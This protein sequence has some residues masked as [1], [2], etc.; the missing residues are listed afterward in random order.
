VN[1]TY[2]A[3]LTL[4][5]NDVYGN[6]VQGALVTFAVP[7]TGAGATL[8]G[9]SASVFTDADGSARLPALTAN[10][11][12]GAFQVTATTAGVDTPAVFTL[13]NT[14]GAVAKLVF[15]QQPSNSGSQQPV[16]PAI[17]VQLQDNSGNA[18]N[19]SGVTVS[20]ALSPVSG[21]FRT[22]GG[23]I[24]QDTNANGAATFANLSVGKAGTYQ[25]LALSGATSAL[26]SSFSISAGAAAT[27]TATNGSPQTATI[28]TQFG[29]PLQATVR[30]AFGNLVS[31][32]LVAFTAPGSG[33]SATLSL[34]TAPTNSNGQV[35]VTAGANETSGAYAV[36][37]TVPGVN[38]PASFALTNLSGGPGSLTFI[39]Q[40]ANTPAGTLI[41]P[42]TVTL[43][44]S[45]G[46]AIASAIVIVTLTSGTGTLLGSRQQ[47][48]GPGGV[49]IFN[50]LQINTAG[51]YQLQV[52][53]GNL[54]A[55]SSPFQITSASPSAAFIVTPYS[56]DQQNAAIGTAYGT[57]LRALVTDAF[58]NPVVNQPVTFTIPVSGA[59]AAF[60]GSA[61]VNTDSNGLAT[62]PPLIANAQTGAFQASAAT[63][64][65]QAGLFNLTNLPSSANKLAFTQQP[66]NTT[67]GQALTPPA[68]AQLQDAS[69]NAAAV[70][71]V[72]ITLKL[73]GSGN[74]GALAGDTAVTD[75]NGRASFTGLS[76]T[77]VGTYQLLARTTGAVSALSQSFV[78]AAGGSGSIT[79]TGGVVQSTMTSATFGQPLQATVR[80]GYGN[81]ATGVSVTFT[82]PSS[83]AS[84]TFGGATSA[85]VKTDAAGHASTTITANSAAGRFAVSAGAVA[86]T[87]SA[88]FT[89]T[90]LAAPTTVLAFT[91]Q[92]SDTVS[93]QPIPSVAVQI[94]DSAGNPV[95][96]AGVAVILSLD[97][98]SGI[99]SGTLAQLTD[100]SGKAA[101][102]D[103][104]IDASGLKQIRATS[105]AQT[106]AV[107]APF[108]IAVGPPAVIVPLSGAP[109]A[110]IALQQ[111]AAPLEAQ[112]RDAA[113]N[114]VSGATLTFAA[115]ASGPSATLAGPPM[116][117]TDAN[118]IAFSPEL[119]ANDLAGDYPVTVT[120]PGSSASATFALTNLP[121]AGNPPLQV[122]QPQQNYSV[123]LTQLTPVAQTIQLTSANGPQDWTSTSSATWLSANP[124]TGTTP[125]EV[126]VAIN[127]AGLAPGS[128]GATVTFSP[129]TN[130]KTSGVLT[131]LYVTLV[132]QPSPALVSAPSSLVFSGVISPS[133]DVSAPPS[134]SIAVSSTARSAEYSVSAQSS[135]PPGSNWL[136]VSGAGT[137]PGNVQVNV[138]AEGLGEGIYA[139]TVT[140]ISTTRGVGSLI[141]PVTLAIG[142]GSPPCINPAARAPQIL[143]LA[144]AG[145][146]HASGAPGATMT[147]FGTNLS[148]A[149]YSALSLPLPT[150]LGTTSVIV[151]GVSAPLY[152][153]SP[154]QIN[155]QMPSGT[156]TGTPQ[157]VVDYSGSKVAAQ[158]LPT[159]LSDVDPGLY[160]SSNQRAA[161][162]NQD[163]TVHSAATPVAA[164][165]ILL[166]YLTGQGPTTPAVTDGNGAPG[167]P[168]SVV[169]GTVTASVGGRPADVL[170]A[171]LAPG[172]AGLLQVNVRI[173]A[174]LAPGDQPVVVSINGSQSNSGFVTVR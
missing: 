129:A 135:T 124:A 90:N 62:S 172:F 29:L 72:V 150:R 120:V 81:P 100:S 119:T 78:I 73:N 38:A 56:G 2:A 132:I 174:G 9:G 136:R 110:A 53:S 46:K 7:S 118:G 28:Q 6:P 133:G 16:A 71:G 8:N 162:L 98:G 168:L 95:S 164:G 10:G 107:S 116:A 117:T 128:Y 1:T 158:G 169:N 115:P 35:S 173:P 49:A 157:V 20:M 23:T 114:L 102:S 61:T 159:A 41:N 11:V 145:S 47:T 19:T 154:T 155:F 45:G 131:S 141:V 86:I 57:P 40:P 94:Q 65:G 167:S 66:S 36:T 170:F 22:L 33:A 139:G 101:F 93:G 171:G 51:A 151:N 105:A 87:G 27:I 108:T 143:A 44:D 112:V 140:I 144:N 3:P 146:F 55:L 21:S 24:S 79:A 60:Q 32:A 166:L 142:C 43:K 103:L 83:G 99:L 92:P 88:A 156:P 91:R 26:S 15:V 96:Q 111:F 137:T 125:M 134:Q 31:G 149:T 34:A 147:I 48:T 70:A 52:Q 13:T 4:L 12:A 152:Y 82:A 37:A 163:L 69:G 160:V 30:D 165:D 80:D 68:V 123:D 17:T 39:Q 18:V 50:D 54:S 138:T 63:A 113:G 89:L 97:S 161:A 42:V 64:G 74:A 127:A 5:V 121:A 58:Q 153:V 59:G 76:V 77:S 14:Q 67:A 104:H 126:A 122:N 25:L 109:Q 85:T 106:P 130:P 84:G 148:E 75:S